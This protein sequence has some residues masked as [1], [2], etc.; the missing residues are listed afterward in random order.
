MYGERDYDLE[1]RKEA[2]HASLTRSGFVR[3]EFGHYDDPNNILRSGAY[4][5]PRTGAVHR[6][7]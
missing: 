4:I 2:A 1:R 3:D 7:M 5:D 6:D